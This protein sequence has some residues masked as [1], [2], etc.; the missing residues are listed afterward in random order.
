M[1]DDA[2]ACCQRG[3]KPFG[4]QKAERINGG[5]V[6]ATVGDGFNR[7]PMPAALHPPVERGL[8][9][10]QRTQAMHARLRVWIIESKGRLLQP[11][12]GVQGRIVRHDDLTII[13]TV[14]VVRQIKV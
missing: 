14:E 7:K 12:E 11:V 3:N 2:N 1:G 5:E 9:I 8:N 10:Q 4:E 6:G 13:L